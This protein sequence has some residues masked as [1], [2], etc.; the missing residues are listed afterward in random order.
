MLD[1]LHKEDSIEVS[2]LK[3]SGDSRSGRHAP[4]PLALCKLTVYEFYTRRRMLDAI[5]RCLGRHLEEVV[6]QK[7]RTTAVV[8]Y[9]ALQRSAPQNVPHQRLTNLLTPTV[10]ERLRY[11]RQIVPKAGNLLLVPHHVMRHKCVT[12]TTL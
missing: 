9:S 5:N 6:D 4:E 12:I 11:F 2:V 3:W 1:C 10:I 7:A 8:Q